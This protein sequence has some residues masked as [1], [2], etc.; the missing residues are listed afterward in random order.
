MRAIIF[1]TGPLISLSLNSLLWILYP[2][3]KRFN[4]S[5]MITPGVKDELIDKPLQGKKY[6]FEAL[7]VNDMINEN[8]L[9]VYTHPGLRQK[10][11]EIMEIAN[12]CF[13][14]DGTNF[15][16]VQLAEM[17]CIAAAIATG[18][19]AV[20]MDERTTRLLIEDPWH[21]K[22]LLEHKLERHV[23]VDEQKL[24]EL[25]TNLKGLK[26][27]RSVELVVA[28]YKLGFLDRYV[29]AN[30]KLDKRMK[31]ILLESVL[32]A[33]KLYGCAVSSYEI[34]DIVKLE[35]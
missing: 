14:V 6:Q 2:L 21:I 4:G 33:L 32:W 34:N 10:A 29:T 7:R 22:D 25:S 15:K 13:I 16:I 35:K 24:G 5:F 12:S 11:E 26:V 18:A 19:E 30:Q 17:E 1:D 27:I 20:V 31:D 28:A 3:K 8:I 23:S 9:D